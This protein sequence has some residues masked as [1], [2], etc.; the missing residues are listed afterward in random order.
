MNPFSELENA[1]D[2]QAYKAFV[3]LVFPGQIESDGI[4]NGPCNWNELPNNYQKALN[5]G[6]GVP[7]KDSTQVYQKAQGLLGLS[8]GDKALLAVQ[9]E[10]RL[11]IAKLV[12]LLESISVAG[13][14]EELERYMKLTE[15][16][17]CIEREIAD[18]VLCYFQ[19]LGC[20]I[21]D[22]GIR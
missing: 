10:M 9:R 12:N 4:T 14:Y 5:L 22:L 20:D 6:F 3:E 15:E 18:A 11:N 17:A 2:E 8:T 19:Q 16:Q 13:V 21:E 1:L 7:I